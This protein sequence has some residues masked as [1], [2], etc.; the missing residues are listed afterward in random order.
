[1]LTLI[2]DA[3]T[4]VSTA[5]LARGDSII[6]ERSLKGKALRQL[7]VAV[8]DVLQEATVRMSEIARIG[9]VQ[10]PGSWT[11]LHVALSSAK[12]FAQVF[13]VPLI[14]ISF[15]DALA[16]SSQKPQGCLMVV[17]NSPNGTMFARRYEATGEEIVPTSEHQKLS[18]AVLMQTLK[19]IGRPIRLAGNFSVEL[20]AAID[21]AGSRAITL[22][23]I[24][25]PAVSAMVRMVTQAP[26]AAHSFQEMIFLEPLYMQLASEEPRPFGD[27]K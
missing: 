4:D 11:G 18:T 3:S 27:R 8:H 22:E 14:P 21:I 2:L 6:A 26:C 9:V 24:A 7:H 12:T 20:V 15:I 16:L 25:Y 5:I 10:G 1:M 13:N 23:Y 19:E 17:Y